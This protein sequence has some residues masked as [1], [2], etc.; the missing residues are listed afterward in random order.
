MG[1]SLRSHS[2]KFTLLLNCVNDE[3]SH[4]HYSN[5][6]SVIP[7][8]DIYVRDSAYKKHEPQNDICG[9]IFLKKSDEQNFIHS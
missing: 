6:V 5:Y 4:A 7:H 9:E 1:N 2:E 8:Y 3:E